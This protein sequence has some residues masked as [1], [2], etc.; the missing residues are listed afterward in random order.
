[1]QVGVIVRDKVE[2][3]KNIPEAGTSPFTV[4]DNTFAPG[5]AVNGLDGSHFFASD[6]STLVAKG[7]FAVW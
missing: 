5:Y 6:P 2:V 1:M 7:Q 4:C 3:L